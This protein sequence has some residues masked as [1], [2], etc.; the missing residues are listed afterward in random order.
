MA[1][2]KGRTRRPIA[3]GSST[4]M[5]ASSTV[6]V[7]SSTN[8][9]LA[10]CSGDDLVQN[11]RRAARAPPGSRATMLFGVV[12]LEA[13]ERS[14]Y[15]HCGRQTQGG[16]NSGR[17]VN[18]ARTRSP[19]TRSQLIEQLERGGIRPLRIL[20]HSK[21]RPPTGET[22]TWSTKP[23]IVLSRCLRAGSSA[24]GDS[25]SPNGIDSSVANQWRA[26]PPIRDSPGREG[27]QLVQALL[28]RIVPLEPR[29]P[30]QL[31][32]NG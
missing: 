13:T 6:L 11:V 15:R 31:L 26:R 20:E 23:S 2:S 18:S 14:A 16:E 29:H 1:A 4:R 30:L 22:A 10:V 9:G 8:S 24:A 19:E 32:M 27:L 3:A 21:H 5:P 28:G 12:A 17:M 25:V 7:S